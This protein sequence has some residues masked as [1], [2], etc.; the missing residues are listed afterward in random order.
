MKGKTRG[1]G[2]MEGRREGQWERQQVVEMWR[3]L[4]VG[5]YI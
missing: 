3:P 1:G 5:N 2:G 4:S